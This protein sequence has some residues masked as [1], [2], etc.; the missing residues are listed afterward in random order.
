MFSLKQALVPFN[1]VKLECPPSPRAKPPP[2]RVGVAVHEVFD[3][4]DQVVDRETVVANGRNRAVARRAPI[5]VL[6]F[7]PV[8]GDQLQQVGDFGPSARDSQPTEAD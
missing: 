4:L 7:S 6:Y 3:D 2:R 1:H 5:L 8:L